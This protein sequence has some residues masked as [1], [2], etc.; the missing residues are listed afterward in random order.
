MTDNLTA[1][2]LIDGIRKGTVARQVRMFTAQGL[3]PVSREELLRLQLNLVADPDRELAETAL[4]S[5]RRE[6][7]EVLQGWI[8]DSTVLDP[9][10]LDIL[11]RVRSEEGIWSRVAGH[12]NVSDETL[13]VLAREGSP[14]IQDMI[15]TNQV[16][17]LGRLEILEDLRSNAQVAQVVLRRVNEFEEEFIR[18]AVAAEGELPDPEP[19]PSL[20]EALE[21]LRA[22]G[23]HLPAQEELPFCEPPDEE[24]A[25]EAEA[26]SEDTFTRLLRRS[27]HEKMLIGLKGTREER[28]ILVN[29]RNR[30][31]YRAVLA[32]PKVTDSEIERYSTSR[33]VV[34]EVIRIIAANP[35]W[36]RRYAVKMAIA[37]NPKT[38][39][40]TAVNL[41]PHLRMQDLK[42]LARDRNVQGP[43]RSHAQQV[44]RRR[45]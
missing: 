15:I 2:G 33:M 18:K 20:E 22:I 45:R 17:V 8:E 12:S 24:L 32:S 31:V 1:Q 28:G 5:I 36:M 14:L 6:T 43:V 34:D 38:P 10:E 42:R 25:E 30:L 29:S 41:L 19:G 27:T 44:L 26:R 35:R 16:R 13:R 3:L 11:V 39:V 23:G 7:A 4:A 37:Q 40:R 21:A 9:L